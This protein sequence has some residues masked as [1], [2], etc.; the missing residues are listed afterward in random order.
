MST[1][2]IDWRRQYLNLEGQMETMLLAVAKQMEVLE[3][4]AKPG[5]LVHSVEKEYTRGR[6]TCVN[7]AYV[8]NPEFAWY[9]YPP[10]GEVKKVPYS[11]SNVLV[12]DPATPGT[13]RVTAFVRSV[14]HKEGVIVTNV[15]SIAV[16]EDGI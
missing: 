13:Y 14:G 6:I 5:H 7:V 15:G 8:R 11:R 12:F 9:I 4:S 2:A 1:A 3:K 10:N 16:S